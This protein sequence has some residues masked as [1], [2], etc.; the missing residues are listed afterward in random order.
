MNPSSRRSIF[1]I[2]GAASLLSIFEGKTLLAADSPPIPANAM[3][4][5]T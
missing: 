4:P 5:E 3:T 1:K 2:I